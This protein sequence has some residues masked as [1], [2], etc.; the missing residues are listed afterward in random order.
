MKNGVGDTDYTL[1]DI[2]I[3]PR[4]IVAAKEMYISYLFQILY[5]VTIISIAFGFGGK[6]LGEY[7]FIFGMPSWWFG[8]VVATILFIVLLVVLCT[9][10]FKEI[11]IEAYTMDTHDK[12]GQSLE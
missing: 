8:T 4:F 12:G 10:V 3:D 11:S 9:R 6:D 5:T 7:T 2:E 1:K